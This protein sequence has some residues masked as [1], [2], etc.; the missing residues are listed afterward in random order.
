MT[1]RAASVQWRIMSRLLPMLAMI[2]AAV[3]YWLSW[4]LREDLYAA[5][6]EIARRS[7]MMAV[8]AVESSMLIGEEGH[9]EWTHIAPKIARDDGTEIHIVDI[10]GR[11]R[12]STDPAR[13]GVTYGLTDAPC[14]VCH[15]SGSRQAFTETAF[16]RSSRDAPHQVFAAPL[17]NTGECRACHTQ[18]GAKLGMV[19][20]QQTLA[21]IH[22]QVRRVQIGIALAAAAALALTVLTV[23]LL[24][25]RHL[26]RPLKRLV[27]GARAI[28]TGDLQHTVELPEPA[29]LAVLADTLN[30]STARLAG[31]QRE[32]VEHERLAAVGEAVA[33]LAHCLKSIL[34]GLRAGQYVID[35]GLERNDTGKLR[36]GWRV[37]Q[38]AVREVEGLTSDMLYCVR[39][40]VA[41]RVPTDP[42]EVI[43]EVVELLR[44]RA[45]QSGV[46]LR[47]DLD[48]DIGVGALDRVL[49]YRAVLNLAANAIDACTE[50]AT[51]NLVVLHSR[52]T[53]DE[54]VLSVEDNGIGMSTETQA[55][56]STRFFST[57]GGS[58]TGL[59]VRVVS[60]IVEEHGGTLHIESTLGEGSRFSMRF[61]RTA[62]EPGAD[63][64]R[65]A[66]G[67]GDQIGESP[68]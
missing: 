23:R 43:T 45:S 39:E 58:G 4:S 20:V 27:E 66:N 9:T 26:D 10:T 67:L 42:N 2:F 33:G 29:E 22:E 15:E 46:D 5:N 8:N 48:E 60:K 25:G 1:T 24:L 17:R 41:E 36:T 35:R 51:G 30:A 34:N 50:T 37:M 57:K 11:V 18:G 68:G 62:R 21:P 32:L 13:R 55:Q 49:I 61:P 7:G 54:I 31:M 3:M 63:P 53:V 40:R 65:L 59:G 56:L 47:S 38:A 44:E 12:F 64:R 6:L 28:G 14:S 52:G 16:V 19:M